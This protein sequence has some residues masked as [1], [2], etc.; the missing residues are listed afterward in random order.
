MASLI[1][2][3][4]QDQAEDLITALQ[5]A[6]HQVA[7]L[8]LMRIEAVTK[9]SHEARLA[10]TAFMD[11]DIYQ[12]VI[13]ISANA[14][15]E[16][17]EWLDEFWPQ[18]PIGIHWY[19]VGPASAEPL[20]QYGFSAQCP[21]SRYDSEGLLALPDLQQVAEQR[22]L[23]WRGVGG[24]ETLA[25]ELRARGARVEYAEL[26][27]RLQQVYSP[28]DWQEVL[29]PASWLLLSSGQALEIVLAQVADLPA[30]LAGI[31]LPSERVAES[32]RQLGFQ[33]VLVPASAR[34]E[35]M[36]ACLQ[37]AGIG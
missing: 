14:A 12:H 1:V 15:R 9:D 26:Y 6:G 2:T 19:G 22:I 37:Q 16:G 35:D 20:R 23:I 7:H 13:A 28:A 17:L 27:Q 4:P 33:Q 18:P 8:P 32:A 5:A 25:S 10:R 34:D 11:L 3:R 31:I 30:R 24:R 29:T 21:A 36:I